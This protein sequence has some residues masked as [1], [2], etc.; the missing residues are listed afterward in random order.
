[1][2]VLVSQTIFFSLLAISSIAGVLWYWVG[3]NR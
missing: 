2:S 1:M 3:R